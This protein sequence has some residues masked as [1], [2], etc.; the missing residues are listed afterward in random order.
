MCKLTA[1]MAATFVISLVPPAAL[2]GGPPWEKHG[3]KN[4]VTVYTQKVE[5]SGVPR[6]KAV[7]TVDAS[8]EEVWERYLATMPKTKGLKVLKKLG[9]CGKNCERLYQ[10]IG[11]PLIA[12]RHYVIEMSWS[13][14][15]KDGRKTFR[16]SWSK[17]DDSLLVGEGALPVQALDGGWTF[18]S[19]DSGRTRI[20]YVNHMDI[21]GSVPDAWFAKGFVRFAYKLVARLRKELS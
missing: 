19:L 6:V 3:T 14:K 2:A 21:G 13:M 4:G 20:V 10:R 15:E 11:H 1:V 7:T 18:R 17:S 8:T 9:S 5:G 12:D 16:R